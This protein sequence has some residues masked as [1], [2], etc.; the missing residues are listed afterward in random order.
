MGAIKPKSDTLPL[1]A[2]GADPPASVQRNQAPEYKHDRGYD[3][4]VEISSWLSNGDATSR[5]GF[6]KSNAGRQGP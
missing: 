4:D 6:D 2:L 3:N 5:P 1:R